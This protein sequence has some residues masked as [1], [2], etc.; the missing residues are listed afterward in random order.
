MSTSVYQWKTFDDGDFQP[1]LLDAL[2][3]LDRQA[4]LGSPNPDVY[5]QRGYVNWALGRHD[6]AIHDYKVATYL[7]PDYHE[8]FYHLGCLFRHL[9]RFR[10][11][12]VAFTEAARLRPDIE[13]YRK[14]L[15]VQSC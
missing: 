14:D 3:E 13:T 2:A 11:A 6:E 1:R 10:E 5:K 9:L 15:E 7:D 12:R 4:G 8:G